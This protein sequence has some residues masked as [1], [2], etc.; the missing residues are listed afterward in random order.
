M[1]YNDYRPGE[2][3][4]IEGNTHIK[5]MLDKYFEDVDT[6]P[7]VFMFTGDYGTGKTTFARIIREYLEI[8]HCYTEINCGK[9]RSMESFRGIADSLGVRPLGDEYKMVVL[10][11]FHA[12]LKPTQDLLLKPLEEEYNTTFL[13]ICTTDPKNIRKGIKDRCVVFNCELLDSESMT[14]VIERVVEG[15]EE[16]LEEEVVEA[17]IAKAGGSSRKALTILES[18]LG[19]DTSD[20]VEEILK[21]IQSIDSMI[22]N[23]EIIDLCRHLANGKQDWTT[24]AAKIRA[25]KEEP[26]S[27]RRTVMRYF[28]SCLLKGNYMVSKAPK[29]MVCFDEPFSCGIDSMALAF[30]EAEMTKRK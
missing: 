30:Y 3:E 5:T 6:M 7:R 26:E 15:E 17:I 18:V 2:L 12:L 11:E 9:D 23:P 8:K 16:E 1:L 4:D 13:V 19:L 27:I 21:H 28:G 29:I 22:E 20:G 14:A 10:D 24:L 25:C